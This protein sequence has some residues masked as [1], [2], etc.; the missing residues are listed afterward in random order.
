[1]LP[2]L[3]IVN[4]NTWLRIILPTLYL[5]WIHRRVDGL[6]SVTQNL[7]SV[8]LPKST[9]TYTRIMMQLSVDNT[10]CVLPVLTLFHYIHILS[11]FVRLQVL[12]SWVFGGKQKRLSVRHQCTNKL[13]TNTAIYAVGQCSQ[14]ERLCQNNRHWVLEDANCQ[15]FLLSVSCRSVR[16]YYPPLCSNTAIQYLLIYRPKIE[17]F[18]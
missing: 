10:R 4:P 3:Y 9:S 14:L 6:L 16:T 1:M 18:W 8:Y 12:W 5:H 7:A 13:T 2:T 15:R 11:L 17:T